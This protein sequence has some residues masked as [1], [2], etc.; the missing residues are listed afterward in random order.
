MPV[1]ANAFKHNARRKKVPR[2][3]NFHRGEQVFLLFNYFTPKGRFLYKKWETGIVTHAGENQI[4]VS[5]QTG[6]K[7]HLHPVDDFALFKYHE[8]HWNLPDFK[9]RSDRADACQVECTTNGMAYEDSSESSEDS[10]E[11]SDEEVHLP[12]QSE[13]DN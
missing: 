1:L 10:S 2:R 6:E 9:T 3:R 4:E 13:D 5:Y 7:Y 8:V 11:S 12:S